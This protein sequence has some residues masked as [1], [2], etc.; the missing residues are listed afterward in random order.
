M[1][2]IQKTVRW[3]AVARYGKDHKESTRRRIVEASG[4]RIKSDGVHASGISTL[5]ADAGLTNGAFYAHFTSKDDLVA[6]VV[7]EQL[8]DQVA[9]MAALPDGVDGIEQF[10]RAYLSV[11]HRDHPGD[12]CPSAALLDEIGRCDDAVRRAYTDGLLAV[13]DV[14]GARLEPAE[15]SAAR[16][17]VLAAFAGMVGTLQMARAVTDPRLSDQLLAQGVRNALTALGLEP[18]DATSQAR[19]SRRT[20][21]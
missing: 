3:H 10:V 14:V 15:P 18:G 2:I 6:S 20:S 19:P 11:E 17:R 9:T 7:A 1:V 13:M 21:P 8:G 4:R 16:V 12:G 5:M